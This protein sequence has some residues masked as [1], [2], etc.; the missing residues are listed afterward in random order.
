[1]SCKQDRDL[2]LDARRT[3]WATI[4]AELLTPRAHDHPLSPAKPAEETRSDAA[5]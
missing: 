2:S 4:V 5:A 3:L 1:M